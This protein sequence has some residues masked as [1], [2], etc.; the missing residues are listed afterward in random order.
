MSKKKPRQFRHQNVHHALLRPP[1]F[2]LSPRKELVPSFQ[3]SRGCDSAWERRGDFSELK[4]T[5]TKV[6]VFKV[7]LRPWDDWSI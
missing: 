4:R 5:S 1:S 2:L 3:L 6:R 7:L